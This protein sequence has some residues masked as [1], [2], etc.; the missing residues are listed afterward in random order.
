MCLMWYLFYTGGTGH[1]YSAGQW[2]QTSISG[3]YLVIFIFI[4]YFL[5]IIGV[6]GHMLI[7]VFPFIFD[8]FFE[9]WSKLIRCNGM[10]V[11]CSL[12]RQ[13]LGK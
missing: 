13:A 7:I 9:S 10:C 12:M 6:P 3:I 5:I 8:T 1:S 11:T 2:M 4:F